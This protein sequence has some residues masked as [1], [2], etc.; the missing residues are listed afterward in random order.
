MV[1]FFGGWLF[2]LNK[3]NIDDSEEQKTWR[4]KINSMLS[5]VF[6]VGGD[7]A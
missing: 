1:S 4:S 5:A 6:L 7:D 3:T 2:F